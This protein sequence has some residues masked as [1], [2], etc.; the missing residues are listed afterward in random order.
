MLTNKIKTRNTLNIQSLGHFHRISLNSF[1]WNGNS[2]DFGLFPLYFNLHRFA[3]LHNRPQKK[4]YQTNKLLVLLPVQKSKPIRNVFCVIVSYVIDHC[5]MICGASVIYLD[6]HY[7]HLSGVQ[8][9]HEKHK[10]Y[11]RHTRSPTETEVNT[12]HDNSRAT[13]FQLRSIYSSNVRQ[14][15][16]GASPQ[17]NIA[18]TITVESIYAAKRH[19]VNERRQLARL[20]EFKHTLA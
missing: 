4:Y 7:F 2:T 12:Y 8:C 19:D 1:A 13:Q 10:I 20:T 9:R 5:K 14:A 15:M 3:F 11:A 17:K 18:T 16:F 6:R